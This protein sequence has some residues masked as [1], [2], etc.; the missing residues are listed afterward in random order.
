MMQCFLMMQCAYF[1]MLVFCV[2]LAQARIWGN[3]FFLMSLI[4]FWWEI[5][6]FFDDFYFFFDSW[7]LE[8][9]QLPGLCFWPSWRPWRGRAAPAAGYLTRGEFH[10][11]HGLWHRQLSQRGAVAMV[12][13]WGPTSTPNCCEI[14]LTH[15]YGTVR[16]CMIWNDI[17]WHGIYSAII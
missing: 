14:Q 17:V 3:N 6:F 13:G 10:A 7:L 16:Y 4:F 15:K 2:W 9:L 12:M 5:K 8:N 11:L 1:M